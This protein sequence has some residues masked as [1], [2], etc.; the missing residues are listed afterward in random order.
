MDKLTHIFKI[1]SDKNRMRIF[2]LLTKKKLC[3]CEL[4]AVLNVTQ[5]S[6][7]RHLKKMKLAGIIQDEKDGFWTNYFLCTSEGNSKIILNCVKKILRE[8]NTAKNDLKTLESIDRKL[9]CSK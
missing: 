4:A 2:S 9:I 1:L 8:N 3:V 6:I 7:S 5:P